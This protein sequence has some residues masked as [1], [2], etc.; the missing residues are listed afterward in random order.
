MIHVLAI[1]TAKPGKRAEV[2]ANIRAGLP[3]VHA[4]PGCIEYAPAV[5]TEI[6]ARFAAAGAPGLNTA[7]GPDT[8]VVVE[9]WESLETLNAHIAALP[10]AASSIKNRGLIV[11]RVVH[12]LSPV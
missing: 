1:V 10:S 8:F 9:K 2:L 3:R 4:E 5:D 12:I 7:L 11:G 6:D